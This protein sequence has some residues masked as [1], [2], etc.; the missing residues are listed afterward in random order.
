MTPCNE[1]ENQNQKK[2]E[3]WEI[4]A[5]ATLLF[6][7][8]LILLPG[9]YYR[10]AYIFTIG[11]FFPETV[12]SRVKDCQKKVEKKLGL[13]EIP[14]E[15]KIL[16]LKAEKQV[17]IWGK[18]SD[19]KWRKLNFYPILGIPEEPGP[20][21]AANELKTPE[22]IYK[23]AELDPNSNFYL[24]LKLDY[25]SAEDKEIAE[26]ENR[27]LNALTTDFL[28]HGFGYS[29][30]NISVT[31]GAMEAIFYLAWKVG[32]DKIS[33]LISPMDFRIEPLPQNI[34]PEWLQK[35]YERLKQEITPL[36]ENKNAASSKN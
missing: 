2:R 18:E 4:P 26:S 13:K 16:F 29:K 36:K 25:P 31:D 33:V 34:K 23:I 32:L 27:D 24:A 28:V 7:I 10:T 15:V 14:T 1:K 6:L 21:L 11:R 5:R 9:H 19:D 22:G 30:Q 12:E 8:P 3:W 35:R 20:K 17:E